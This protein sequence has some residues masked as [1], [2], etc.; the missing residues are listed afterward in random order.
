MFFEGTIQEGISKAVGQ[1]KVVLCFVTDDGE[2]S[3]QW[4]NE[5]LTD[6]S[7]SAWSLWWSLTELTRVLDHRVDRHKG[8]RST[9]PGRIR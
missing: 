4:E 2:E 3:Q 6:E 7:V 5:F 1:Q 9:S 8:S